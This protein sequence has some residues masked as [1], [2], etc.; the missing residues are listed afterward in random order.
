MAG[1]GPN[2]AGSVK[3][4][5]SVDRQVWRGCSEV[6]HGYVW[7]VGAGEVKVLLGQVGWGPFRHGR[8]GNFSS[9]SLWLG[10]AGRVRLGQDFRAGSGLFGWAGKVR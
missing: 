9:K 6:S 7:W 2:R 10:G 4:C 3:V 5:P 8:S 1:V